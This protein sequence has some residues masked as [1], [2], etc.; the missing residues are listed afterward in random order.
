MQAH[1]WIFVRII[2]LIDSVHMILCR[3][4]QLKGHP[5]DIVAM[6][7]AKGTKLLCLDELHVSD[8]ADALILGQV[9]SEHHMRCLCCQLML[10]ASTV[11]QS[12]HDMHTT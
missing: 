10:Q 11:K 12:S 7:I 8:V 4:A 2:A 5:V 9:T 3:Y 6:D 1:I